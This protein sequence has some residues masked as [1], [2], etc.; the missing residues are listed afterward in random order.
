MAS[1]SK[2]QIDMCHGPLFSKIIL[3]SIPLM[4]SNIMQVL[5]H[6]AD[7]IVIGRYAPHEAMAAVGSCGALISLILNVFFGLSVGANVLTARFIGARDRLRVSQSVHTAVAL[8]LYGGFALAILGI[9]ISKP[10]LVMM[11]TPTE[12]L[13]KAVLYIRIVCSGTPFILLYNFGSSILR[14]TG[15]TRRPLIYMILSGFVNVGLNLF[16]VCVF[17][18]DVAGVALATLIANAVSSF[19]VLSTLHGNR[20]S[21]RLKWKEIRLHADCFKE[22]LK[23]GFPAGIQGALFSLSNVIIQSTINT[24]GSE[25]MAGSAAAANLEGIVYVAFNAYYFSSISFVGQNHGAG[26][27]K[28]ILK[29]IFYCLFL[30]S[31]TAIVIGW[32]IYLAGP[33][34]MGFY[35][36]DPTVIRWGMLRM[37]ILLTTYMLCAVMDTISGSLRGLGH[38]LKPMLVTLLGVCIFRIAWVFW[39]F[40]LQPTMENLLFSYPISWVLVAMVNGF[41]LFRVCRKMFRSAAHPN[42]GTIVRSS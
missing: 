39:I 24:F 4:I 12:V 5:F 13:P 38:S 25:A 23:I 40:P 16:F 29:S 27:Y 3:F 37:K 20:D 14:S 26:K 9:L 8:A 19:L 2:Y 28:R 42:F 21:S 34:L 7:L 11:Q 6:A 31:L 32:G 22:I 33:E 30:G 1:G 18:M 41:I 35:N 10:L 15:D 36:S 17:H